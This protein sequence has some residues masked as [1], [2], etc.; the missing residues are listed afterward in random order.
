M[1]K[2]IQNIVRF[3]SSSKG[4][5][6]FLFIWIVAVVLLSVL[7]PSSKEYSGTS[8]ER[9]VNHN[10]PSEMADQL[11][12]EQFPTDEGL[13][14]LLVF[15]RENGIL[16]SD[17]EKITEF[18]EW[19]ASGKKPENIASALPYHMFPPSV[20]NKMFSDDGSTL[21]FNVSLAD[22]LEPD[23]A[24]ETLEKLRDKVEAIGLNDLQFDITGPAGISA[25]S[26]SIFKNADVVLMLSTV[27]LIFVILII[28]YRS[29]ILAITPLIIAGIVYGIVDRILGL[30]GQNEWFA[31]DSSAVSIMLVLLF[32]V[33]TDYSLF[34]FSRYREELQKNESKY[35]S[36]AEA[37]H[38]VSEP[39]LFSGGTVLLAM[40]TLFFTVFE[41]YN[42]FAPV[43]SVAVVVILVAGLTLIPSI[44]ALMGRKAFWP[45]VPKVEKDKKDKDHFWKKAS[46]LVTNKPGLLAGALSIIFLIGAF[47][48]GSINFSFNLLKSFPE[49][50]S[51][52]N[53]FELLEEHYPAGELAPVTILLHANKDMDM[54]QEFLQKVNKLKN[55]LEGQN[56]VSSVSPELTDE[57]IAGNADLPRNFLAESKQTVQLR[58]VLDSNPYDQKALDTIQQLRDAERTL[59]SDSGFSVNEYELHYA[60]QTAQ[61]LDVKDMNKRDMMIL[62]SLVTVLLTVMLGVQTKSILLPILMMSTILLSYFAT[63]GFSWWIFEHLMGY[64]AISYRLPVYTF[65]FMVALGVDYNIML[66]SRIKENAAHLPW[67]EAVGQG[68]SLTGGVISSA[69]LILAATFAVLMT[70]P[71]Q[72]LFL[73]GFTMALGILL[74]TFIIRGLFLPS[75]LILT[76]RKNSNKV[77]PL[78][79]FDSN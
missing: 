72:E 79:S 43:F 22:D 9:S 26:I 3:S 60:G 38:Y 78:T 70:Q 54:D 6:I 57:M 11:L 32:A 62:F 63:L 13:T 42:H 40:L 45:F 5:K 34:V 58:L 47:H 73:F 37:M 16:D 55:D 76:H 1:L 71:L 31:V 35:R 50:I 29:P 21:I 12:K 15:H 27:V 2:P 7:A 74:D 39:I 65:V 49:D 33:L 36:M 20:Q 69:G 28:I 10:T 25:D 24:H 77:H 48:F 61:Q 46:K 75:I 59:L 52:R 4:A 67:K 68:V 19:L 64:D 66:V 14:A 51:S 18:S 56:G 23:E 17:K 53:G 41:P 30:A 44:F 8:Q